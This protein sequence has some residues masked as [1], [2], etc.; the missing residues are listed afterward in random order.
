MA[1]DQGRRRATV[2]NRLLPPERFARRL[3]TMTLVNAFGNGLSATGATLYFIQYA[4]LSTTELGLALTAAGVCG[5]LAGIPMGRL[6]DRHD[7]RTILMVALLVQGAATVGYVFV[8]SFWAYLPLVCALTFCARG[9]TAVRNVLVTTVVP[10]KAVVPTLAYLRAALNIGL[11]LGSAAAAVALAFDEK[12]WYVAL[13]L[14]DSATFLI[15]GLML[16]GVPSTGRD[17]SARQKEGDPGTR[18]RAWRDHP[19]LLFTA[20]SGLLA[21][22]VG[23]LDLGIV[24]WVKMHTPAPQTVIAMAIILNTGLVTLLQVRFSRGVDS[25]RGSAVACRRAGVALAVSCL[26]FG[27]ATRGSPWTAGALVLLAT[28]VLTLGEL[29]L[30]A[31][32]WSLSYSLAP[33][34]SQGL[35]QGVFYTGFAAA[36]MASP[37]VITFVVDAEMAGWAGMGALFALSSALIPAVARQAAKRLQG[38]AEPP[39]S[40]VGQG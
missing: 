35:Y 2:L 19:Y 4:G 22:H 23:I 1:A 33:A 7:P 36:T 40:R 32:T 5:L 27:L 34:D 26:T 18:T 14:V 15:S 39:E 31:G 13:L 29:W 16:F 12:P 25:V 28:A 3:V 11:A 9:A 24:L 37:L 30:S 17:T 38:V 20:L 21:L 10:D 6:A 8:G